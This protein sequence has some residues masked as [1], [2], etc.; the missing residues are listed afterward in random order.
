MKNKGLFLPYKNK[1]ILLLEGR[2]RQ[3]LPLIRSFRK[4]G[5]FVAA[6]CS[7]RLDIAYASRY[8]NKKYL[9]ICDN[10]H[11]KETTEQLLRII[12][13]D[14]FEKKMQDTT[15][16]RLIKYYTLF[17]QMR[18]QGGNDYIEFI[19]S[20]LS[21]KCNYKYTSDKYSLKIYSDFAKFER[22][23]Y[24]KESE[25][26]LTRMIAGYAWE[27][28]SKKDHTKSMHSFERL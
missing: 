18:V 28:K 12:E 4:Q 2:A 8:V 21:G 27:W 7:S 9:G 15:E 6:L 10:Q 14:R 23:M 1:R 25:T 5:C 20:I 16:H 26:G 11:E 13:K 24:K 19:K 3:C 22:D 17:T